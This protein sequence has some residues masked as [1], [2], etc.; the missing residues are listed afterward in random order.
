[1]RPYTKAVTVAIIVSLLAVAAL[2][3]L[4][5]PSEDFMPDNPYWNGFSTLVETVNITFTQTPATALDPE[6]AVLAIISPNKNITRDH[7]ELVRGF[8]EEGGTILLMDETGAINPILDDLNTGLRVEGHIMVDPVFY[9]GSW[10]LPK[11]MDIKPT[12]ETE[13]VEAIATDIPS[14]LKMLE[15]VPKTKIIAYSSTFTFQDL[16]EDLKPSQEEP[17]GPFPFAAVVSYGKGKIIVFSDSSLFINGVIEKGDNL[18][19]LKNIVE[20]RTLVVDTSLWQPSTHSTVRDIVLA[21]YKAT[22]AP[23][24]KYTL[25]ACFAATTYIWAKGEKAKEDSDEVEELIKK[26][27]QWSLQL[28]RE[29][30]KAREN[31]PQ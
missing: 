9:Y 20:E 1:M 27:P 14:T 4:I 8:A 13:N 22:S 12:T 11:I 7:I 21:T 3:M 17:I 30:K 15:Q 6:A 5:P 2:S 28:L 18:Q 29:L 31:V 16:E 24:I 26:H 19:L 10:R 23:E 25:V